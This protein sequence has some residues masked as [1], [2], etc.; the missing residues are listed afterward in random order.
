MKRALS[1][2]AVANARPRPREYKLT[3][4]GGLYL[5]VRSSGAKAWCYKYRLHGRQ[6][7]YTVGP[8]PEISLRQARDLHERARA[9]VSSGQHPLELKRARAASTFEAIAREWVEK[10]SATWSAS[11][12]HQVK[13]ALEANLF[14]V[15]G[16][17]PISEITAPQ[18]LAVLEEVAARKVPPGKKQERQTGAVTMAC[19][20]RQL[21]GMIFRYA[22]A[23]RLCERDIAADLQGAIIR[24]RVRHHRG[25]CIKEVPQLLAALRLYG[26]RSKWSRRE[27]A[28]AIELLLL[29][30]VRTAE[31]RGATWDEIDLA[32]GLWSIKGA[33]MKMGRDHLVP[34]SPRA[35]EL[36]HELREM[37][38]SRRW[39]FPNQREPD[40]C[41]SPTTINR[42]LEYLGYRGR[43]TGHGF[44]VT[45]STQ[46]HEDGYPWEVVEKQLAHEPRNRVAAAYNQAE[47]LE[48]RRE[49]M[50]AWARKFEIGRVECN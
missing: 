32:N 27:T 7:S 23:R 1:A 39:L 46:L 17:F 24:P 13:R 41:M 45:A 2:A 5:R 30:F 19:S 22:V 29:T 37:D 43:L 18:L 36:L 20:L 31:L 44:R 26:D 35:V 34:L 15:L 50:D 6:Y 4:G 47:Y 16:H 14:P 49:M 33:R 40:R 11:Y 25:L 10:K 42:A 8:S 38:L 9:A 21:S 48:Q 3:D 12:A 28:I